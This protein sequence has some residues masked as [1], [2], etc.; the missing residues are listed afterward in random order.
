MIQFIKYNKKLKD[1]ARELRNNTTDSEKEFWNFLRIHFPEHHFMRQKPLDQFIVDFYCNKLRL[2]IEIDGEVHNYQKGRDAERDN[3]FLQTYNITTLRFTNK[4][5]ENNIL[6]I[7]SI[8]KEYIRSREVPPLF[9]RG[10]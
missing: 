9:E 6:E 7:K 4:Q 10:G 2:I 1:R 3:I 5:V 8:I